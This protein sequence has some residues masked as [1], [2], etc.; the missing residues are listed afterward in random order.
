MIETTELNTDRLEQLA[1]HLEAVGDEHFHMG[2][3]VEDDPRSYHYLYPNTGDLV[4]D[5]R[6][7]GT[8]ACLAGHAAM[9]FRPPDDSDIP[10]FYDDDD[11]DLNSGVKDEARVWLGLTMEQAD[12]LFVPTAGGD[13]RDAVHCRLADLTVEDAAW[14]LRHLADTGQ[15]VWK[16][17]CSC[18]MCDP[19]AEPDDNDEEE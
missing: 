2:I 7:C 13:L 10:D 19:D 17:W 9:L 11:E 18:S 5:I 6:Q 16:P 4:A 12:A 15:V 14:T 1:D 8:R 3:W